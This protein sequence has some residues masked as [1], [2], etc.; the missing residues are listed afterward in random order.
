MIQR[1]QSLYLF[2]AFVAYIALFFLPVASFQTTESLFNF[3]SV[4][5]SPDA[6]LIIYPVLVIVLAAIA[7]LVFVT[8]FLFKKR[9]I[10]IRLTTIALL[11]NVLYIGALFFFADRIDNQLSTTPV[12]DAGMYITLIPL[13]FLVLATRSIKKDEKLVRSTDRLR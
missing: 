6:K 11:L 5:S 13:V 9:T 12:Y 7:C 2:I 3:G 10:Q 1:I 4:I 8:I